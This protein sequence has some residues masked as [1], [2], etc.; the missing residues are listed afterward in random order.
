M[1]S[2]ARHDAKFPEISS[3]RVAQ[4]FIRRSQTIDDRKI[5]QAKTDAEANE[6]GN[7]IVE[8]AYVNQEKLLLT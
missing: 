4:Q 2:I 1:Q 3:F 8:T 6:G 7:Y 5:Q